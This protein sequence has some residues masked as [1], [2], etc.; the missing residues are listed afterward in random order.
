MSFSSR[1]WLN[2][3]YALDA[4]TGATLWTQNYGPAIIAQ[5][6]EYDQNISWAT[7]IGILSTPVIDPAT[8]YHVFCLRLPTGQ[9]HTTILEPLNAIDITTGS[10]VHGSPVTINAT[11]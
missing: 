9:R 7:R 11:Y 5:D 4:D 10:P 8:N 2:T 6:V 3:I 1:A